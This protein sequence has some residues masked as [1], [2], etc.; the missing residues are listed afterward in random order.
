MWWS[1]SGEIAQAFYEASEAA[2]EYE[3]Y[4]AKVSTIADPAQASLSTISG[5]ITDLS[6]ET[7][8]AVTELSDATYQA[9]SA[10]VRR[11]TPCLRGDSDRIGRGRLHYGGD[12][13]GFFDHR[14]SMP[15]A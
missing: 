1:W 14:P 3:T 8:K 6:M 5:E 10:G 11:P 2:A 15:T 9:L 12:R 4:L 7:G 13:R